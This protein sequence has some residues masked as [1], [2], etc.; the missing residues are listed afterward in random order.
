ML[1]CIPL[2]HRELVGGGA[3]GWLGQRGRFLGRAGSMLHC[4]SQYTKNKGADYTVWAF[5]F[6]VP[7]SVSQT[8]GWDWAQE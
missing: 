3:L 8:S 5:P 2:P 1:V 4:E 7:G 6:R